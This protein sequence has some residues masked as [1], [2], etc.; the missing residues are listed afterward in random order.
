MRTI[1]ISFLLAC[2]AFISTTKLSAQI[3]T[4]GS[5]VWFD[6]NKNGLQDEP[7]SNGMN[8]V[9]VY[10]YKDT[11]G[12]NFAAVDNI[13]TA[14][15]AGN[16]GY[17]SFNITVAG[18]YKIKFPTYVSTKI[19]T[20]QNNA[21]ATSGNSDPNVSTGFSDAFAIDPNGVGIAKDN[22]TIDAGYKC[23]VA[24]P[25]V[26]AFGSTTICQGDSVQLSSSSGYSNYQWFKDGVLISG[27][28]N[29][30]YFASTAGTYKVLVTD[31][32]GCISDTS[33]ATIV[34]VNAVPTTPTI[35]A[36]GALAFCSGDSVTLTSS[37]SANNQWYKDGVAIS[38]A[39][40]QNYTALA[41][42]NYTVKVSNG[43]CT[44]TSA[45]TVVTHNN[46]PTP[47]ITPASS[48]VICSGDSI[49]LT[50]SAS[51]N[52]QWYKDGVIIAG[53]T[54]QTYTTLTAGSYTVVV[55]NSGCTSTSAATILTV[56]T[57][58][59]PVITP[60]GTTNICAGNNVQ[61]LNSPVFSSYQW[62]KDGVL[63]VGA[64][65]S[66]YNAAVSGNYTVVGTNSYGCVSDTSN[67][68]TVNV[69]ALPATPT[70]S[71]GGATTFCN[72]DSVILTSSS[73]TNNQ[74]YKDGNAI[75]GATNQT[76]TATTSG[77][78]TVKVTNSAGCSSTSVATSVTA[79]GS[80][81][82]TISPSSSVNVCSGDSVVLTSS[83][84]AGNQWYK[85]GVAISGATNQTYT[86]TTSGNYTVIDTT[87]GGC[88]TPPSAT[89]TITINST[90]TPTVSPSDSLTVC[91][92]PGAALS[93]NSGYSTYQWYKD[94]VAI[95][96]AN[97]MT[98]TASVA[99]SYTV[100]ATNGTGCV[101]AAS[102]AAVVSITASPSTPTITAG[103][104]T[105]FCNGDSVVLTSSSA[106]NNQWYLNGS[107]IGGATNQTYT[108]KNSGTYSVAVSNGAGCAA[109]STG[110]LVVNNTPATAFTINSLVQEVCTNN[111]QFTAAQPTNGNT[112]SWSF[113]DGNTDTVVNPS[114]T[115]AAIGSF[116][117]KQVVTNTLS[118]CKDS[119]TQTVTVAVCGVGSGGGGGL[120]TKT[121]G[122]IIAQ[123][124]FGKAYRSEKT[125]IDYATATP[126]IKNNGT[127]INGNGSFTLA[128][129]IPATV[130]NTSNSYITTPTDLT[131]FTNA[132]EVI[133]VDY[134]ANNYCKAVAFG[135]KTLGEIYAHTKPICD[136]LKDAQLIEIKKIIVDGHS[137]IASKMQ[138]RGGEIEYCINFSIG[139]K[140]GRNNFSIQSNWMTNDYM[141]EDTLYNFQLWSVSYQVSISMAQ[142]ILN[143]IKAKGFIQA[144]P[145]STADMPI[146]YMKNVKR[147]KNNLEITV[148]NPTSNTNGSFILEEKTNEYATIIQRNIPFTVDANTTKI[149]TINVGDVYEDNVY[150]HLDNNKTDLVYMNDGTWNSEYEK[151][152]TTLNKFNVINDANTATEDEFPL[153][154]K[155]QIEATTKNYVSAYKLIKAG[156]IEKDL[157]AFKTIK[158]KAS[159]VG[160]SS[161]KITLVK[162]G[163]INWAD[164]YSYTIAVN[165]NEEEYA[166]SLSKFVSSLYNIA[167]NANDITA[168]NFT[169]ENTRGVAQNIGGT[170]SKAKFIKEDIALTQALA[171]KDITVFPNPNNG[172]FTATFNSEIETAVVLKLIDINTGK[173]L[174]NQFINAKKGTNTAAVEMK[175]VYS[176]NIYLVTIEG[177][178]VKYIP[179]KMIVTGKK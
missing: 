49:T 136:R 9:V 48:T 91:A 156:G 154:R 172:K 125:N 57:V 22:N 143:K 59:T 129:I 141:Q 132:I 137:I 33:A 163:I 50:S 126:F 8:A 74:W 160:T 94:G 17:Y 51:S 37:A 20:T 121:L 161:L 1:R 122:D 14:N 108:A 42:G 104:P 16:A 176:N 149:I 175:N 100:V 30:S 32:G 99:G 123:R 162:K 7:T 117:V 87:A 36:G 165:A 173:V 158:F 140:K 3:G 2:L 90:T 76:Y 142:D 147:N 171:N 95:S 153:Y 114:H 73:A 133:S 131:A 5:Y 55:T 97:N 18:T 43:L 167:I 138:Q 134:T 151:A 169:W 66:S 178:E 112:Y 25:I 102:N 15:N 40:N 34:T 174:H 10:L 107:A 111:F 105:S 21:A 83:A 31:G 67:F 116:N 127:V 29:L 44:A 148:Y 4:V 78:Y 146:A 98:Y 157:T 26:T 64:A 139:I 103:G 68:A 12:G 71:A 54:N 128:D 106:S 27:A 65:G 80:T 69:N 110:T 93:A 79:N 63:I 113:G 155:V 28:N 19:L 152:T 118:G 101:S 58:S 88:I 86:A 179:T 96:G 135:T 62:F 115:Y 56:S 130:V 92:I 61:L 46:P 39:I 41:A 89:T 11:G 120:E 77:S 70:I 23:N 35:S 24:T 52:N 38:G 145:T 81:A 177:D 144:I 168:I 6:E 124:L 47:T 150:M 119:L 75:S 82:P 13:T 72:G 170:I 60:A 53:A 84:S 159:S 109:L 45:T 164:Q 166:I 85:N